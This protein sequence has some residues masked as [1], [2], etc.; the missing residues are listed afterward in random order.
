LCLV[1]KED[2][3][4]V[5]GKNM[6]VATYRVTKRLVPLILHGKELLSMETCS[7]SYFTVSKIWSFLNRL[8]IIYSSDSVT[9]NDAYTILNYLMASTWSIA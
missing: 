8:T 2:D 5:R 9:C 7:I 4:I 3:A 6:M 1:A